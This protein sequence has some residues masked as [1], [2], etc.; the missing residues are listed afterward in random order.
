[1]ILLDIFVFVLISY[2]F[3]L[4]A[5]EKS[6]IETDAIKICNNIK[7]IYEVIPFIS[8]SLPDDVSKKWDHLNCTG[9]YS[10][11]NASQACI[12]MNTIYDIIPKV[13]WGRL[14]VE[15]QAKWIS[16]RCIDSSYSAPIKSPTCTSD[17]P[18]LEIVVPVKLQVLLF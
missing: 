15:L 7:S 10:P 2:F 3:V 14:P 5:S 13:T 9:L 12:D 1:M 4:I 11:F 6:S 18:K 17:W 16:L 8:V